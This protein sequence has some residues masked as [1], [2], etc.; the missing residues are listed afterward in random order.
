MLFRNSFFVSIFTTLICAFSLYAQWRYRIAIGDVTVL[1]TWIG[2]GLMMLSIVFFVQDWV[3]D[4]LGEDHKFLHVIER[5]HHFFLV[6]VTVYATYGVLLFINAQS[7]NSVE[8]QLAKVE[9]Q[10]RAITFTNDF[11]LYSWAKIRFSEG[12]RGDVTALVSW[13]EATKL[14]PGQ[15]VEIQSQIG[16]LGIPRIL[17]I[18][19]DEEDMYKNVLKI[20]PTATVAIEGLMNIYAIRGDA[21]SDA[22]AIK[23]AEQYIAATNQADAV[24]TTA[25]GLFQRHRLNQS[26]PFFKLALDH[27]PTLDNTISYG[28]VLSKLGRGKEGI[29]YL[30][31]AI[32]MDPVSEMGYYHLA[33]AQVVLGQKEGAIINFKEVLKRRPNYPEI[34]GQL[35]SLGVTE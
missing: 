31:K 6:F 30:E 12:D 19:R 29:P 9:R 28:W 35:R 1:L 15:K 7:I 3:E 21:A 25:S 16:L 13:Q 20:A 11:H 24:W 5:L 10:G 4:W 32:E 23:M 14:W 27:S 2:A 33:Y 17:S 22:L 8:K 18:E 34:R 26:L